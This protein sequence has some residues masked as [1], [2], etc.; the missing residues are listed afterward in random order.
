MSGKVFRNKELKKEKLLEAAFYLFTQKNI[1]EVSI[2]EIVKEAGIAKGT[3]YLYFRDKYELRDFLVYTK[4]E[5]I[6]SQVIDDLGQSQIRSFEDSIIFVI[7]RIEKQFEQ[8][9][10]LLTFIRI[11]YPGNDFS[12]YLDHSF[13]SDSHQLIPLFRKL[14]DQSG[15]H[16]ENPEA[17]L[18][19]V[20]ELTASVF[21]HAMLFNMPCSMK[22]IRPEFYD[23]IRAI[24]S[25]GKAEN[26]AASEDVQNASERKGTAM[27]SS[28]AETERPE[29]VS[30]NSSDQEQS[31]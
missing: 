22:K 25:I 8:N 7:S 1:N 11:N 19:M 21:Y 10:L 6:L 2:A 26:P 5:Q 3:F 9:P 17:I 28:E 23:A 29:S 14:A 12:R 4:S 24:L 20:L 15:Y 13:A 30:E 16:F 27:D 31:A 18:F